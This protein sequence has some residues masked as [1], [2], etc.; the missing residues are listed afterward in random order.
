MTPRQISVARV[1]DL[2]HRDRTAV[3]D[4]HARLGERRTATWLRELRGEAAVAGRPPRADVREP[5]R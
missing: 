3:A 1:R 5:S 2:L 4:R